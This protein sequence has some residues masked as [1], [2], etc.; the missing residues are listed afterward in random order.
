M[1]IKDKVVSWYISNILAPKILDIT[2]PGFVI[3]RFTDKKKE[4]YRRE[5]YYPEDLLSDIEK[6]FVNEYKE[7]GRKV[8]YT[9]GKKFGYSYA[10]FSNFPTINSSSE[11]ELEEF[12]HLLVMFVAATWA[13]KTEEIINNLKTKEFKIRIWDYVICSKNGIGHI[14]GDGGIAGVWSYPFQ[15]QTLEG[16]Q[17][18]CQGRGEAFCEIYVAPR[19]VLREKGIKFF[20][21]DNI[22]IMGEEK[23]HLEINRIKKTQF[24][25][26]SMKQL[27]DGGLFRF[28]DRK[29]VFRGTR[30]FSAEISL[31]YILEM[32]LEKLNNGKKVLFDVSFDFGKKIGAECDSEIDKFIMDYLSALGFG[33]ILLR[34]ENGKKRLISNYFPW[35]SL[36][37]QSNFTIFSGITSGLLSGSTDKDIILSKVK[38]KRIGSDFSVSMEE[39]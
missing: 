38:A 20:E 14:L 6:C 16:V 17:N 15:D 39:I 27:I 34:T 23:N 26:N 28:K 35:T 24:S 30:Y 11:K 18:V 31:Y 10:K 4:I 7:E 29:I 25:V 9:I 21:V 2:N 8:L 13:S 32:E 12:S 19:E 36:S 22:D 37:E 1:A 5:L 33:D 3:S